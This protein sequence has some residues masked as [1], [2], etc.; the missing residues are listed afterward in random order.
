[1]N[2]TSFTDYGLRMLMRMASAPDRAFST[3][4]LAEEFKLSRN[5]LTKIMQRLAQSGIVE[6]RRGVNGGAI[7][8]S[9]PAEVRLGD[10]VRLLE[11]G[12][13][14]VECFGP[15]GGNCSIDGCCRLKARLR[16]AEVSFI[17]DLNRSTLADIALPERVAA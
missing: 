7:L 14:L 8:R 16:Q 15:D 3:A 12:Q 4:D 10:V 17:E 5:H 11:Q 9:K 13:A 1:M 6:T 2:L